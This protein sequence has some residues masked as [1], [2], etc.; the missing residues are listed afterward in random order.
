MH[1]FFQQF[2]GQPQQERIDTTQELQNNLMVLEICNN[3]EFV[4]EMFF[5]MMTEGLNGVD[6]LETSWVAYI[7]SNGIDM[8]NY[9]TPEEFEEKH[10]R[11]LAA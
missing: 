11:Q 2:G 5:K 7:N 10:I 1:Q 3:W 9:K 8:R 6:V 4:R